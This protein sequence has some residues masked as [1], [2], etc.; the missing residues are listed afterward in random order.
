MLAWSLVYNA[1]MTDRI[2][3]IEDDARL[4]EMVA[5]YLGG[6]GFHV[7]V[8][9]KGATGLALKVASRSMPSSSISRCPTWTVSTCAGKFA[10]GQR[11]RS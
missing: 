10:H 11:L 9:S 4:A 8:A 6:A 7:T 2:L 1:A 3:L 5:T